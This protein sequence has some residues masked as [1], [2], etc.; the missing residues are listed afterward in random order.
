MGAAS[1][2]ASNRRSS[3]SSSGVNVK[4]TVFPPFAPP[5]EG[6][7]PPPSSLSRY[8]LGREVGGGQLHAVLESHPVEV[9]GVKVRQPPGGEYGPLGPLAVPESGKGRFKLPLC[10]LVCSAP[11]QGFTGG[12]VLYPGIQGIANRGKI[13]LSSYVFAA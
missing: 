11:F 9:L 6:L 13:V 7:P 3:S 2:S 1:I 4:N 8:A 12:P 10:L 5:G